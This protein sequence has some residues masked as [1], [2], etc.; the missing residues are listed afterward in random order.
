MTDPKVRIITAAIKVISR[1]GLVGTST[2]KIA[3]EAEVN[4]AM[5]HYYFGSKDDLLGAVHETIIATIR[6]RIL[7]RNVIQPGDDF[8]SAV[9]KDLMTF[10]QYV[11]EVPEAQIAQYDLALYAFRD[12]QS[13][14]RS[15]QQFEMYCLLVEERCREIAEIM[16]RPCSIPYPDLARF[17]IAGLDGLTLQFLTDRDKAR[18]RRNLQYLISAIFALVDGYHPQTS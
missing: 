13:A 3:A 5:L 2:R 7:A 14:E 17:I 10:W 6:E 1:E 15:R 4:L 16:H 8:C 9:A 11:E 18:A 12:P